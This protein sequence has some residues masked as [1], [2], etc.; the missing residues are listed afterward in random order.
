MG[1]YSIYFS[2]TKGTKKVA[3]LFVHDYGTAEEIDLCKP[4]AEKRTF[5]REDVCFFAV[6]SYG[7]RVPQTAVER[8]KNFKG[9]GAKAVLIVV[10]GNRHY[11][12]TILEL[13]DVLREKG[14]CCTAAVA[15]IAEHSIMRQ[16]AA[17]RPD[18]E[19]R[20]QLMVF[21]QEIRKK[22]ETPIETE[23]LVPGKRPYKEY[24]GVS[25]QPETTGPCNDC[26]ICVRACPVC[27]IS[28]GKPGG[29]DREECISCMRCIQIC[30]S[31][32]R[33]LD[34]TILN[35]VAE[36]MSP[37]FRERKKNELFL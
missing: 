4:M 10:Y 11:D 2:P 3:D 8:M 9:N 15:A 25:L 5:F 23:V 16:F 24:K 21:A 7:G 36:K 35:S 31:H 37:L 28:T 27:A 1:I 22:L 32:A 20:E 29:T 18:Q 30:P 6:P 34:E 13:H 26:G 19:D 33:N 17:G 12:D 14:F